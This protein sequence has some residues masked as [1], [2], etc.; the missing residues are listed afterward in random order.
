MYGNI[1]TS[2]STGQ[3][4]AVSL[5]HNIKDQNGQ[6]SFEKINGLEGIYIAN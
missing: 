4:F 2:D 5:L 1:Y 6:S 3:R